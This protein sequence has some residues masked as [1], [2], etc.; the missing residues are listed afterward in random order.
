MATSG[1]KI[2]IR[3]GKTGGVFTCDG[4]E[5]SFCGQHTIAHR[6][7]LAHQLDVIGQEHD[8]LRRDLT[9]NTGRDSILDRINSW[10]NESILKINRTAEKA[11]ADLR[12]IREQLQTSC[13]QISDELRSSRDLDNYSETD[14]SRWMEKLQLL[15]NELEMPT[16]IDIEQ[17][18]DKDSIH[19]IKISQINVT[20][21]AIAASDQFNEVAGNATL[22]KDHLTATMSGTKASLDGV[23]IRGAIAYSSGLH[24]IYFEIANKTKGYLFFGIMSSAQPLTIKTFSQSSTYGWWDVEYP[25]LKGNSPNH[26]PGNIIK[27]GDKIALTLDCTQGLISYVAERTK[28]SEKLKIDINSCPLPWKFLIIMDTIGNS[29]HLLSSPFL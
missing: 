28:Q 17:K 24:K 8:L 4:C 6:Q 26:N 1:K 23:S 14:L 2:C 15:R 16:R 10:E 5:K 3:C 9:N 22:S 7:E 27:T 20:N 19:L 18:E 12:Q 21:A 29:V 25:V 13:S 11:R